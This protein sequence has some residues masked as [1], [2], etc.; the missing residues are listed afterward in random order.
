MIRKSIEPEP[1]IN[2][3]LSNKLYALEISNI[4]LITN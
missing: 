2:I 3:S 1:I 4:L